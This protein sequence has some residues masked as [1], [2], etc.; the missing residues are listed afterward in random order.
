MSK[1][2]CFDDYHRAAKRRLPKLLFDYVEGGSFGENT[3]RRNSEAMREVLLRQRV[4][5][6]ISSISTKTELFGQTLSMPLVLAPIGQGGM[7]RRRGELQAVRAAAGAGVPFTLSTLSL[8]SLEE[9]AKAAPEPFWFQL[10]MSKDR[11]FMEQLLQRAKDVGCKVLVFTVDLQMPGYR[12]RDQRSGL[13]GGLNPLEQAQRM[14]DGLAHPHWLYDV[15][16][17]G[18]PHVFGNLAA[19]MPNAKD[20]SEFWVWVRQNFD[21]AMTWKDLEWVRAR[22]DGP[23]VVKGVQDKADALDAANAGA[24]GVI[25]SNHGGR[26]LDSTQGSIEA[27]PAI[28]EAVGDRLTVMMDGGVHSGLDV[29]KALSL[30]AKA[31]MIGRAWVWPLAAR[32]EAG[33]AHMLEVFRGELTTAMGLSGCIDVRDAGRHLLV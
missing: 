3:L 14:I 13:A 6:D 24:D 26:Q 29:L 19:A 1:L 27:L 10:Y 20:F 23:I 11:S 31:C 9:V 21:L 17:N 16:L 25:V 5:K 2:V 30:G 32:G 15:F 22:W 28:A 18:R 8:C 33:V 7:T 12:Y 4:M